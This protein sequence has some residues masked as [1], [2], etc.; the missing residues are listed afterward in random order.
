MNRQMG[1]KLIG[2]LLGFVVLAAATVLGSPI[3]VGSLMG[4]K[5]ATLDGQVPLPHTAIL[6]GDRLQVNEGLAMVTLNQGNR[7]VM[8]HNSEASFSRAEDGVTVALARGTMSIYHP[9]ASRPFQVK[10]GDV[11]VAPAMGY[12]T[13][14]EVAMNN[15]LLVVTA[16]DGTL[17]VE[18]D[19]STQ[20]VSKGKTIT[21][22][23]AATDNQ[24]S[25]PQSK[26]H[27]K[28]LPITPEKAMLLGGSGAEAGS[29]AWG[30]VDSSG[31]PPASPSTP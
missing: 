12:R 15:G 25:Y 3:P 27:P 23:L 28:R 19:G 21:I 29:V 17:K 24:R 7:L 18:R 26:R 30:I 13:I 1:L 31:G 14:G 2:N 16:K 6:N 9:Q 4:S 5:N 20:E 8:G 22:P 11:S 10:I